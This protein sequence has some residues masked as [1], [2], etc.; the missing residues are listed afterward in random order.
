MLNQTIR[1]PDLSPGHNRAGAQSH[2]MTQAD[3]TF[4]LTTEPVMFDA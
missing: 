4:A 2:Y 3:K 1:A